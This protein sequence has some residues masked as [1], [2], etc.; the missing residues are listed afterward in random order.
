MD[1]D[2]SKTVEY[3]AEILVALH[4][5]SAKLEGVREEVSM[6]SAE[7]IDQLRN[8]QG[9]KSPSESRRSLEK[10][11][12][13]GHSYVR[14]GRCEL[15]QETRWIN[16]RFTNTSVILNGKPI[17]KNTCF[18]LAEY[19]ILKRRPVHYLWAYVIL[20][21]FEVKSKTPDEQFRNYV[22][23]VK[24]KLAEYG[25]H[26]AT[27]KEKYSDGVAMFQGMDDCVVS[28]IRG[29][30]KLYENAVSQHES[31][32]IP[33]AVEALSRMT[34]D[35][36]HEWYTFTD[37]YM[38]LATWIC[39]L[40]FEG[41][42]KVVIE[43]CIEFLG[44]YTK[45]LRL[46]ISKIEHSM[47]QTPLGSQ[48][49][50]ELNHIEKESGRAE[51]LLSLIIQRR[52][53]SQDERDY[54]NTVSVMVYFREK[55]LSI[56]EESEREVK[57]DAIAEVVKLLCEENNLLAE[58]VEYGRDTLDELL[59]A[60]Q[61]RHKCIPTY[62]QDMHERIYWLVGDLIAEIENFDEFERSNINKL[63]RLKTYLCRRLRQELKKYI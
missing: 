45:R 60:K 9:A 19:L 26:V 61:Q 27:E 7:V 34:D 39:E 13:Q 30:L 49:L 32:N 5:V 14:K 21:K 23:K 63:V 50:V 38:D 56:N 2:T 31:N 12:E 43:K 1:K 54:E 8:V 20:P 22:S 58:V 17:G 59:E 24:R 52:P 47:Q 10:L 40:N 62:I 42:R 3:L 57:K 35:V 15:G 6:V 48:A 53:V 55:L 11:V 16:V 41:V 18:L 28:N 36:G 51:K 44:W 33:G 37:A 4:N 29:I 25:I 46:G